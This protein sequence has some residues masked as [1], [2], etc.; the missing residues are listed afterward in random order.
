MRQAQRPPVAASEDSCER[1]LACSWKKLREGKVALSGALQS[2]LDE[3]VDL[4]VGE[5]PVDFAHFRETAAWVRLNARLPIKGR[6]DPEHNHARR[7]HAW[8]GSVMSLPLKLRV[9]F[10]NLCNEFRRRDR[11]DALVDWI[12]LQQRLPLAGKADEANLA[13]DW[14]LWSHGAV[15][16]ALPFDVEARLHDLRDKCRFDVKFQVATEIASVE[17]DFRALADWIDK[18]K[19]YPSKRRNFQLYAFLLRL[20]SGQGRIP[21]RFEA[22]SFAVS[23][24]HLTLPTKRIV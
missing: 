22:S 9:E 18:K 24:T 20:E 16:V 1:R 14:E 23:Y 3:L 5:C 19:K 17:H 11:W 13:R 2:E 21:E 4:Y 15:K 10:Q 6:R 12:E 7:W 8:A